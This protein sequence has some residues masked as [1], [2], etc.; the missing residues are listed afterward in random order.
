VYERLE[1]ENTDL[2]KE[3]KEEMRDGGKAVSKDMATYRLMVGG[4][5]M[6]ETFWELNRCGGLRVMMNGSKIFQPKKKSRLGEVEI[7]ISLGAPYARR[8]ETRTTK[9]SNQG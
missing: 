4:D 5:V 6:K 2:S 9:G 1:G 3:Q 8:R 7:C